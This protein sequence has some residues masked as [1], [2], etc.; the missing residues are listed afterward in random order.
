MRPLK[1]VISAFG[2]YA[3]NQEIDFSVFGKSGLYLITGDTGAGKTS[4]FD[5]IS[6]ALYGESSGGMRTNDMLRS[7]YAKDDCVTFVE[8]TFEN[9]GKVYY[10]K[11]TPKQE[12]PGK[13]TP[14]AADAELWLID[15]ENRSVVVTGDSAVTAKIQGIIGIDKKKFSQ[16]AMIAQGDFMRV[17]TTDTKERMQIFRDLFDT[18][19][20]VVLQE[21]LKE[22]ENA[23]EAK[24]N[25]L[26]ENISH[27]TARLCCDEGSEYSGKV[28]DAKGGKLMDEEIIELAQNLINEYANLSQSC[29]AEIGATEKRL[30]S[31]T[32]RLT[33]A[34]AFAEDMASLENSENDLKT[35]ISFLEEKNDLFEQAQSRIPERQNMAD[36]LAVLGSR[37]DD[38]SLMSGK[39]IE[40]DKL[41][42]ETEVNRRTAEKN[43]RRLEENQQKIIQ[44]RSEKEH[45]S[46]CQAEKV[47][48]ENEKRLSDERLKKLDKLESMLSEIQA[49][50]KKYELAQQEYVRSTSIERESKAE[51]EILNDRFLDGQAGI[52]AKRLTD[53]VCCPVCGSTE[54]PHKAA[55]MDNVPT[56]EQLKKAKQLLED[57]QKKRSDD[58]NR[59]AELRTSLSES[60]KNTQELCSEL[61]DGCD[62][63]N[64]KVHDKLAAC[65]QQADQSITALNEA[66]IKAEQGSN[67][68]ND[69]G[70][71]IEQFERDIEDTREK[72]TILNDRITADTTAAENLTLQIKEL[73]ENLK[74]EDKKSAEERMIYLERLIAEIN[75][76]IKC[77]E[78]E[79]REAEKRKSELE[80]RIKQ[81]RE[82]TAAGCEDDPEVLRNE[83]EALSATK[84]KALE[85]KQQAVTG[86]Y[87]NN[88]V[89]NAV[90]Q[91]ISECSAVTKVLDSVS[92]LSSTASGGLAGKTKLSLEAFVQAYRFDQIIRK[93]NKRFSM[94][95]DQKFELVRRG[96]AENNRSQ[97]GLDL[98]IIDHY[99]VNAD[100]TKNVRS[101]KTLSGGESFKA[102]LSLALGLAEEIQQRTS[103]IQIDTMFIDEGFGSLDEQSLESAIKTLTELSGG[104]RLVGIISHVESLK[105]RID[106]KLEINK[107]ASGDSKVSI[108]K[109]GNKL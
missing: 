68:Y 76:A 89:L 26:R 109:D 2:P 50:S 48:L 52:I 21:R 75:E 60:R 93:A 79:Q 100:G 37:L 13:K 91:S 33:K 18:E 38:Y 29:D 77:A 78:N 19:K 70:D 101:V 86:Q 104:D 92:E 42:K 57:A 31:I 28:Q 59:S 82:K 51:Y 74:Y 20:Y 54:H 71:I 73:S 98:D 39:I 7:R 47:R 14:R 83:Q 24:W 44:L 40:R 56:E 87:T 35:L 9:H 84:N 95:T 88:N 32:E 49:L 1:L 85:A 103:K 4:L 97:S 8:L 27:D 62:I 67:R 55:I 99:S 72:Q 43:A 16:I 25:S 17:L 5:A 3:G 65:K 46:D 6:Y 64:S 58:S 96:T 30:E 34:E 23:L 10:L 80:G 61:L 53:G 108:F 45:L 102:A 66:I 22:K 90:K 106:N 94:M 41:I 81:L 105:N 15:G 11:R 36:E 107:S 69:L 12:R 63:D